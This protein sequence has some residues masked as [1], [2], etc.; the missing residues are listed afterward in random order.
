MWN[1]AVQGGL[2]DGFWNTKRTEIIEAIW[3]SKGNTIIEEMLSRK[4]AMVMYAIVQLPQFCTYLSLAQDRENIKAIADE[5]VK[6]HIN[7]ITASLVKYL[8]FNVC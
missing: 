6:H 5:L 7:D 4:T 3:Q 2:L 8:V 1:A